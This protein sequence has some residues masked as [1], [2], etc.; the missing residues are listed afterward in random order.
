MARNEIDEFTTAVAQWGNHPNIHFVDLVDTI[1]SIHQCSYQAAVKAVNR[2]ATMR[3]WLIGF[4]IVE[5]Q[6]RG[7]D[8]ADYGER[9]LKQLEESLQTRGLNVTL[10]QNSRLFY[11]CYPQMADLFHIKIQP[12]LLVKSGIGDMPLKK[13]PTALADSYTKAETLISHLSFAHITELVHIKDETVRLF[14][15]NYPTNPY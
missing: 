11:S 4:L 14:Y 5:Y 1:R 9:L 15:C 10:F 13:Q 3:N 12:T 2:Y 7:K 6:Q 8:R